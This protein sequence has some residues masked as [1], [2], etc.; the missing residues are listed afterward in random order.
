MKGAW[1]VGEKFVNMDL[2]LRGNFFKNVNTD[3]FSLMMG[4]N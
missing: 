3:I 4:E 1:L 2:A